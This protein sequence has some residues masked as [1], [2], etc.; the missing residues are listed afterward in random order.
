M[1]FAEI[2]AYCELMGVIVEEERR[3]LI[4]FLTELDIV[5]LRHMHEKIEKG[6]EDAARKARE[7]AERKNRRR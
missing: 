1:T 2:L 7:E 6:R 3:D 5:Y 4:H